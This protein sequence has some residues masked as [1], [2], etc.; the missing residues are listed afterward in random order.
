MTRKLVG[1]ACKHAFLS[2]HKFNRDHDLMTAKI[3]EYYDDNTEESKLV[4]FEDFKRPFY[5]VLPK[6]R[7]FQ[8]KRDY[9][10]ISKTK[11][12]MSNQARLAYNISKVLYGRP[13][14]RATLEDMKNSQYLFGCQ[15]TP[16]VILKQFF[17]DKYPDAQ[18][19]ASYSIAAYDIETDIVEDGIGDPNMASVTM[20]DKVY[21]CGV[22]S[23]FPDKD[24][25]VILKKLKEAEEKYLD[26]EYLKKYNINIVY[27]LADTPAECIVNNIKA[28]HRFKPD[29]IVSWNAVFDMEQSLLAL[30]KGGYDPEKVFSDPKVPDCYKSFDF[31]KG[32]EFK[33]KVDGTKTSLEPQERFPVLRATATWQWF[34]GMSFYAISRT[35]KGKKDS[36]SLQFTAKAEKVPGKL[37]TEEGSHL[38][39]GSADWHKYMQKHHP[40][41]YAMYNIQDNFVIEILNRQTQDYSLALP[42]L[43]TSSELTSYQSQ[44]SLISDEL[45]FIALKHGFV[46][47]TVGNVKKDKWKDLKPDLR[48]WIALLHTEMC[49]DN[50]KA[51]YAGLPSWKSRAHGSTNDV[52]IIGS[53]PHVGLALNVS[54]RSTRLEVC[55]IEG[56]DR[57]K[58][59]ELGVNFASSP[60]ANATSL[61]NTMFGLPQIG[62]MKEFYTSVVLPALNGEKSKEETKV[63]TKEKIK[64]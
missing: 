58:F 62:D 28:F 39:E 41:L 14:P 7:T 17:Y 35:A 40:Y 43:I 42:S 46:W 26:Q 61:A 24:P 29:Y 5:V 49:E 20:D 21:W 51:I 37:Y 27:E 12:F 59:R 1:K 16:P 56:L 47:G 13:D 48:D 60:I 55:R 23:F 31:Y 3:T 57:L 2:F 15:E 64:A 8:D 22:K 18:N 19:K 32:R 54:N 44:P 34:D 63:E 50:G 36:Y 53:Y 11:K 33:R 30:E 4:M 45:S 38:L 52:D 6:Y 9:I 10:E 25:K